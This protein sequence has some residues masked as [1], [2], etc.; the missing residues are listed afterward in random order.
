MVPNKCVY[1][2]LCIERKIIMLTKAEEA[3]R[4]RLLH[5]RDVQSAIKSV[6]ADKDCK[7]Y[8]LKQMDNNKIGSWMYLRVKDIA[9]LMADLKDRGKYIKIHDNLVA[10]GIRM[11]NFEVVPHDK[12][13][14]F[15][16]AKVAKIIMASLNYDLVNRHEDFSK[17]IMA[18]LKNKHQH[19]FTEAYYKQIQMYTSL[20]YKKSLDIRK[21]PNKI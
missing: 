16:S 15:K 1:C 9:K 13:S 2:F 5:S 18:T 4:Q 21:Y 20:Y 19:H 6:N 10:R 11:N 12:A 8:I 14:E 17:P 7:I 3:E